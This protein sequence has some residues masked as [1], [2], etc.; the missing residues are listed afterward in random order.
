MNRIWL[1]GSVLAASSALLAGCSFGGLNSLS[2]PGTAGHGGGAYQIIVEMEDVSTLPQN[3]PVMVDDVTVGS[4][5]GITAEQ[6]P[7]GSFFAAVRLALDKNVVLPGNAIAKVSQTSLLGSLHIDLLPPPS[8][9][10]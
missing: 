4:V 6:R 7:D 2:L 1:R 10:S 9:R 8:G 3:S 5:S